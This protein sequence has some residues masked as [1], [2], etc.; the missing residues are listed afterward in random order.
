MTILK[1][2]FV[3]S[4]TMFTI[5]VVPVLAHAQDQRLRVSV[6]GATTAGDTSAEP[7]ITA[8]V[9]YRFA[10]R[11]SFDVDV[12]ASEDFSGG[13][14][15]AFYGFGGPLPITGTIVGEPQRGVSFPLPSS[16]NT[17]PGA[18]FGT[19]TFPGDIRVE[20]DGSTIL[21]TFGLRYELPTQVERFVPYVTGGLGIARS[22]SEVSIS[23]AVIQP[24]RPGIAP[25]TPPRTN[26][27][28][29]FAHTGLATSAGIG[30]SIRIFKQLSADL[31][32]RYF[33]LDRWRNLGRFGGGVSYRF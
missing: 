26:A 29:K 21:A 18:L 11:L 7:A 8:S 31:D 25:V 5:L 22:E 13:S 6:G 14:E 19:A 15:V 24:A 27:N 12:T 3:R 17:P 32:A 4:I 10:N 20:Q 16:G 23:Y 33:R 1:T 30:A 28:Q 9:G 2:T